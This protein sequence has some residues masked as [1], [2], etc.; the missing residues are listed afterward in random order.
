M[1]AKFRGVNMEALERNK[2]DRPTI[3]NEAIQQIE[4]F[5]YRLRHLPQS[6]GIS[7]HDQWLNAWNA[8]LKLKNE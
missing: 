2:K 1:T 3:G 7:K 6:N 8:L 4:N 5:F